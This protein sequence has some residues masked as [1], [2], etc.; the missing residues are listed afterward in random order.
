MTSKLLTPFLRHAQPMRLLAP[1]PMTTTLASTARR[2]FTTSPPLSAT[3]SQVARGCRTAQAARKP[4]SPALVDRPE[5][6]GVC[7]RVGVTK[8]KKPNSGERKVARVR[9]S[10]GRVIT[11]YIPGEGMLLSFLWTWDMGCFGGF[12]GGEEWEGEVDWMREDLALKMMW[13]MKSWKRDDGGLFADLYFSSRNRSQHPTAFRRAG[14][15]WQKSGLSRCE[16]PF[17]QRRYGFGEF[18]SHGQ[19]YAR[20]S[21]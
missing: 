5:M 15:R 16:V 21:R 17:G 10:S 9:L 3:L 1:S 4:T 12:R 6:K 8:P 11:A 18:C 19:N 13:E 2:T 20:R 14:Q 7:L